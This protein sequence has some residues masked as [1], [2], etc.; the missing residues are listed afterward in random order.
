MRLL[1]IPLSHYC[2][3]ARWALEHAGLPFREEQHLQVF[4]LRPVRRAGGRHTVPLL[5]TPEGPLTDSADIVAH[6][7]AH[8]P[9]HRRLYPADPAA[10]EEI[11]ALERELAGEFGVEVRRWAYFH[12]LPHRRLLL[13]YNGARAPL[14]ERVALRVGYRKA[15]QVVTR[16]LKITADKVEEGRPIIAR[17]LDAIAARLSDGRRYLAG[18]RFTAADLTFAAMSAL[19]VVPPTYGVPLPQPDQLPGGFAGEVRAF[20]RHPAGVLALRLYAEDRRLAPA[21]GPRRSPSVSGARG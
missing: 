12:L 3:R 1:T 19:L 10:R 8:A 17:Q 13:R 14:H 6:A 20:R 16:Y 11:L 2:E 9:P 7:D 5:V 15:R 21:G 18:E 4:H